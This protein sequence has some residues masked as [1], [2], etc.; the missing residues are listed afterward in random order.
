[1]NCDVRLGGPL[2]VHLKDPGGARFV[3]GR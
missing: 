1:V 3:L 2:V